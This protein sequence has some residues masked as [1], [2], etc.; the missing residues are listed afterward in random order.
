MLT[1]DLAMSWRRGGRVRPYQVKTEDA[2]HLQEAHDLIAVFQQHE[3]R[4]RA[5]LDEALNEYVGIGTDYKILRGLIKLLTDR[6]EFET[7]IATDPAEIR[8]AVFLAAKAFHPMTDNEEARASI[9]NEAARELGC[10]PE[11]ALDNLYADL[12]ENQILSEFETL[13]AAELLDR[14]NMAQAQALLYRC[15]EMRLSVAAQDAVSY[16]E[17]FAAIKAYRLI[18]TVK[19]NAKEGYEIKLNGPVSMFHRSQKYGVQMAVFLPALL[20]CS[21]WRMSAVIISKPGGHAQ[22][23]L[24]SKQTQLRSHYL[25]EMP[26][27]S[28][29]PAAFE[30]KWAKYESAWTLLKSNEV[31]DLGES[32]FIPDYVLR[33][34]DGRRVYLEI[35]GFWTPQHLKARMEEFAHSGMRNFIIAAWDELRGSREPP[36]RL[37]P[38]VITFKRSLDPAIVELTIE[39]L[40]SDEE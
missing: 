32:A 6:C 3:G 17:L 11:M 20:T 26:Y 22:F 35:L 19:G 28:P 23:E 39:K 18:H 38:N 29:A 1:S 13:E 24:D 5:S 14:Y 21:N 36:A 34:P 15:E 10:V 33:H 25:K 9:A 12:P 30:A 2:V 27:E 7:P 4:T 31:I 37:P 16:R 40:L 8:R